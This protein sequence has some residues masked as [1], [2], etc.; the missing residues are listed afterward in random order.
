MV[1]SFRALNDVFTMKRGTG[2][3]VVTDWKQQGG[4]LLVSGD[5]RVIRVWDAHTENQILVCFYTSCSPRGIPNRSLGSGHQLRQSSHR[6]RIRPGIFNDVRSQFRRW[7]SESVRSTVRRGGRHRSLLRRTPVMG[8]ECKVAPSPRSAVLVR[9]V[10]QRTFI[11]RRWK[12]DMSVFQV[13]TGKSCS[14][15]SELVTMP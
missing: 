15:T 10:G 6:H 3:G 1:S 4:T 11:L 8:T 14:G 7:H 2:S 13:L 5:S 9:K 12:P